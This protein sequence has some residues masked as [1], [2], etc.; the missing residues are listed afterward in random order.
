MSKTTQ[1]LT[2]NMSPQPIT[3]V[4]DLKAFQQ[5][6]F[7]NL[8]AMDAEFLKS[9]SYIKRFSQRWHGDQNFREQMLANPHQAI[10][11][12]DLK[13]D[14]EE[15][16]P[17]WDTTL[18]E[19]TNEAE[20]IDSYPLLKQCHDLQESFRD[21]NLL[22][23]LFD[24]F[25]DSRFQAWRTRQIARSESQF[26]QSVHH[27]IAQ[28]PMAL[29]LSKGCSVGC[30]FCGVSAP[31]LGDIFLYSPEN[32]KLWNEVLEVM[33]DILGLAAGAGFCYWATDPLD[34]PDYEKFCHDFH[35]VLGVFPQTTTAQPLKD[36]NRTKALLKVSEEKGCLN[37]RFSILSLKMLNQVH[38]KF[39]PE[40][41]L[42]VS[43]V[44]QNQEA[45]SIKADAGRSRD[46]KLKKGQEDSEL[47]DQGTIACVTGFL[48]NMV[49]RSVKLISPCNASER[50][51][52]GYIVFDEG[53]FSDGQDLKVLLE[54][55][56]D[57]NMPTEVRPQDL[58]NFRPDLKYESLADGFK[59]SNRI[60]TFKFRQESS[61]RELGEIIHQGGKT[62]EEIA[63]MLE[64]RGIP[65][66]YTF[67]Y[68]N[69]MLKKAVLDDE[70]KPKDVELRVPHYPSVPWQG[71]EE[72]IL[73]EK[74]I[75][76][77]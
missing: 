9:I 46:K 51:P 39:T 59:L 34:N 5:A 38:E 63:S 16:R 6:Q 29:E 41:L 11:G 73:E 26:R 7:D 24:S 28:V 64:E 56:I 36:I 61:L 52:L 54:R 1:N 35:Q 76:L 62:A 71:H 13:V 50:W 49:E 18:T 23:L 74:A 40:E 14:P 67:H 15:I 66:A 47:P 53:T 58:V 43:L 30:H 65:S 17:V 20:V 3:N 45:D 10:A 70:P 12:Y 21:K 25:K 60:K 72:A 4:S 22:D 77:K 44:L 27:S 57:D 33:Q 32:A 37:N 2:D 69:L 55:M 48:F 42:L 31:R 8:K 19:N 68:L 75:A